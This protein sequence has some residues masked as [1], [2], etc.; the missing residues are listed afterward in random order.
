MIGPSAIFNEDFKKYLRGFNIIIDY[1][2]RSLEPP[3]DIIEFLFEKRAEKLPQRVYKEQEE[4]SLENLEGII[5][6][7]YREHAT[8]NPK[9][10]EED[11]KKIYSFE[12]DL[13]SLISK[14]QTRIKKI[15]QFWLKSRYN[16]K[17][18]SE[19][20]AYDFM[21][22][23]IILE[24]PKAVEYRT[25]RKPENLSR[26]ERRE[27]DKKFSKHY[28]DLN[29]K[30]KEKYVELF[31]REYKDLTEKE[32]KEYNKLFSG[33]HRKECLKFAK[34]IVSSPNWNSIPV[35]PHYLIWADIKL[36]SQTQHILDKN[37]KVLLEFDYHFLEDPKDIDKFIEKILDTAAYESSI[38]NGVTQ[39]KDYNSRDCYMKKIRPDLVLNFYS[40]FE[41]DIEL[42]KNLSDG[43]ARKY[44]HSVEE[45]LE[46]LGEKSK[47]EGLEN[48][49]D[50]TE[51]TVSLI[52]NK[53]EEIEEASEKKEKA[54]RINEFLQNIKLN[55]K[56]LEPGQFIYSETTTRDL[57]DKYEGISINHEKIVEI[58]IKNYLGK[59]QKPETGYES[60]HFDISYGEGKQI[61]VEFQIRDPAMDEEA[62]RGRAK[63]EKHKKIRYGKIASKEVMKLG[64]AFFG[65]SEEDE[66]IYFKLYND[67]LVKKLNTIKGQIFSLDSL[68]AQEDEFRIFLDDM[69]DLYDTFKSVL[70]E[71]YSQNLKKN[72]E[73][74]TMDYIKEK[75]L[76]CIKY[77]DSVKEMNTTLKLTNRKSLNI[78]YH[79]KD[80]DLHNMVYSYHINLLYQAFEEAVES[81]TKSGLI[82]SFC[83]AE[84][85][86]NYTNYYGKRVPEKVIKKYAQSI[87][88]LFKQTIEQEEWRTSDLSPI[89]YLPAFFRKSK[90]GLEHDFQKK[91]SHR[92]I[93]QFLN[94]SSRKISFDSD[95]IN[96][97]KE[98][99][100]SL[101]KNLT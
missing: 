31:K 62:E 97:V 18:Q 84:L 20:G 87:D 72:I 13:T 89:G 56:D 101:S 83:I 70:P 30:E 45:L 39:Y 90:T 9:I 81:R 41:L 34:K 100:E 91:I 23:R 49:I 93:Q 16:I 46:T 64:R 61:V 68:I 57:M 60:V 88:T 80:K 35:N 11:G 71:N 44:D 3:E 73:L 65:T 40:P 51:R 26:K 19:T 86:K 78:V 95:S 54:K 77:Y 22:G 52:A 74:L 43:I 15:G 99:C 10:R 63:H 2:E 76:G 85:I 8:R 29:E 32:K 24:T 28:K 53:L 36:R 48:H 5:G 27:F 7:I 98:A 94:S 66:K 33:I 67:F 38:E 79:K 58:F 12:H 96:Y 69:L 14:I 42:I 47:E 4:Y 17:I 55:L 6:L 37:D 50:T 1:E 75:G 21:G 25:N 82:T 92:T 59:N